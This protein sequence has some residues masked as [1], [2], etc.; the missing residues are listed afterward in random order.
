[1]A[2]WNA[3]NRDKVRESSRR[4]YQRNKAQ[5]LAENVEWRRRNPEKVRGYRRKWVEANP[6]LDVASKRSYYERNGD[7][8]K[9]RAAARYAADPARHRRMG[10]LW[11]AA[12]PEKVAVYRQSRR[13]R[14]RGAPGRGVSTAEWDDVL[15]ESCGVCAYCGERPPRLCMDHIEPLVGGGAHDVENIAAVCRR[16]NASKKDTPLVVWLTK[17]AKARDNL[18]AA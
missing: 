3:A 16:C 8:V 6:D 5:R 10:D 14:V 11:R 15:R 18:Q 2:K 7:R 17:R 4:S 1:M 13:A 9:A 12:N